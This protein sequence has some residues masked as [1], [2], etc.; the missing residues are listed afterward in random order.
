MPVHKKPYE[1]FGLTEKD[2]LFWRVNQQRFEKI[3]KDEKTIILDIKPDSN[4][5]GDFLFLTTSR[6]ANQGRIC[7]AFYGLGFHESRERWITQEW[8]WY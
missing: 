4:D 3:L 7:M 5:F 6:P 2:Q 1:E 8:F